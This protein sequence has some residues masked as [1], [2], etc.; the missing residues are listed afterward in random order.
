MKL[1]IKREVFRKL[2]G[3]KGAYLATLPKD[4]EVNKVLAMFRAAPTLK[5]MFEYVERAR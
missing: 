5:Q 2:M 1:A 3:V 4:E